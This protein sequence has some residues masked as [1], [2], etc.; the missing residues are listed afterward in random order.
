M[1]I[2][3]GGSPAKYANYAGSTIGTVLRVGTG[4]DY[5]DVDL[6][7]DY[8]AMQTWADEGS[9][10]VAISTTQ[11][12]AAVTGSGFSN[13]EADNYLLLSGNYL[14]IKSI[15]ADGAL[16]LWAGAV[17]TDAG[18]AAYYVTNKFTLHLTENQTLTDKVL[19]TGIALLVHGANDGIKFSDGGTLGFTFGFQNTLHFTHLKLHLES[20]AGFFGGAGSVLARSIIKINKTNIIGK[21]ANAVLFT[22]GCA[23]FTFTENAGVNYRSTVT[24][25]YLLAEGTGLNTYSESDHWLIQSNATDTGHPFTINNMRSFSHGDVIAGQSAG[26]EFNAQATG[27]LININTSILIADHATTPDVNNSAGQV[28]WTSASACTITITDTYLDCINN[29]T[30]VLTRGATLILDNTTRLDGSP[31]RE[32]VYV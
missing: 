6:A 13:L 4:Q 18:D 7:F 16:T 14:P 24:C 26:I 30:D 20:A 11:G 31:V 1:R 21:A 29:T 15:E 23:A 9:T 5:A 10:S 17:V 12:S 22:G 2:L 25:D 28:I 19:P 27:K 8:L 32:A 3:K